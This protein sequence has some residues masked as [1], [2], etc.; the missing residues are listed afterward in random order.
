MGAR[1]PGAGLGRPRGSATRSGEDSE[2]R[3]SRRGAPASAG[4]MAEEEGDLPGVQ[5]PTV[6]RGLG[7]GGGGSRA[8]G[9][10]A[11]GGPAGKNGTAGG[12]VWRNSEGVE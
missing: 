12:D 11:A 5:R 9:A 6:A 1:R 4:T 10:G 2:P 7:K 8:P 3:G